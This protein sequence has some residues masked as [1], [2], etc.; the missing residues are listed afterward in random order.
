MEGTQFSEALVVGAGPAG[1]GASIGLAR[2]GV[3][4]TILEQHEDLG[5]V[6]R[7]E[8]IRANRP[9]EEILGEGFF[10]RIERHRIDRRRYYSHSGRRFVD[11]S[12][13][14]PNIIFDWPDLIEVMSE[15]AEVSGVRM[16]TGT[17]VLSL[18]ESAGRVNGVA[19]R[20]GDSVEELDA[21]TVI[22][23]GGCDDP[24]SMHIGIDRSHIDMPVAKMLVRGYF[25]PEDRL[26]YHFHNGLGGLIVGAVFPRGNGEAEIILLN[27]PESCGTLS[28]EE[29]SRVHPL[30][31]ERMDEAEAFYMLETKIPMGGM[32]YPF[33]PRQGL[34]M[35]G[36][37]L[38]HVQGR[39]GSGIRTS[40]LI[41]YAAGTLAAEVLRSGGW[42][43]ENTMRFEKAM[44]G[45]PHV[46][47]L[48][49]HNRIF[50]NLRSRMF[51]AV[52]TPDKMDRL[53]PLLKVA[54]R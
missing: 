4:V 12:I 44:Q 19:V 6:R 25:G 15:A 5:S 34:V 49:W 53:W 26:E 28:F 31:G 1:L 41:G 13:S 38:G 11:R 47:S 27:T 2:K 22:S 10:D 29:F 23:C 39:G 48:R 43:R 3:R 9:M 8:T 40:F 51:A 14:N 30:F 45:H 20:Q 24:A 37:A 50:T 18:L 46:R 52:R 33:A 42:T 16:R 17:H 21:L 35:A 7:G 32:I 54:L 36:D